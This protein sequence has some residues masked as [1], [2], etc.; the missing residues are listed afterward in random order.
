MLPWWS[1]GKLLS[2]PVVSH[3]RCPGHPLMGSPVERGYTG[4]LVTGTSHDA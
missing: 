2:P 4:P 3:L 1:S